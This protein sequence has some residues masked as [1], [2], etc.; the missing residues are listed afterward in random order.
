MHTR[1]DRWFSG[2]CKS[3]HLSA[4][5]LR[6]FLFLAVTS[7]CSSNVV[8]LEEEMELLVWLQLAAHWREMAVHPVVNIFSGRPFPFCGRRNRYHYPEFWEVSG[9]ADRSSSL[10]SFFHSLFLATLSGSAFRSNG[11]FERRWSKF[12]L[13]IRIS[14]HNSARM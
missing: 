1:L 14:V 7:C 10:D 8:I 11:N 9:T 6:A 5:V 3:V 2:C 4:A 13:L 12:S